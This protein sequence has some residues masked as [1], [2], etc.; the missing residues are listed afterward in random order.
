MS[1]QM[2]DSMGQCDVFLPHR[3]SQV[4]ESLLQHK[5]LL[6]P[7]GKVAADIYFHS[8]RTLLVVVDY[9][10]NFIEVDSLLSETSK[11]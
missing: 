6:R 5:V 4:Q 7:W 3:D 1:T 8:G 11:L 9:F 2:K 10:S